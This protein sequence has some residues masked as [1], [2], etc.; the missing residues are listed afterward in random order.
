MA[1]QQPRGLFKQR[2][3]RLLTPNLQP[4]L[5]LPRP[6]PV[7][8]RAKRPLAVRH[9]FPRTRRMVFSPGWGFAGSPG[10]RPWLRP[11]DRDGP[12]GTRALYRGEIG[13]DKTTGSR[14]GRPRT[15]RGPPRPRARPLASPETGPDPA[16]DQARALGSVGSRSWWLF[17]SWG[18][19]LRASDSHRVSPAYEAGGLLLFPARKGEPTSGR[20]LH[21]EGREQS[22][23]RAAH[24]EER[25]ARRWSR[26]LS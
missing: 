2:P 4:L 26:G 25:G 22:E 21:P 10:P 16:P 9:S 5:R 14:C 15:P 12:W 1:T 20:L 11:A 7:R 3:V 24:K 17:G 18:S 8:Q 6:L 23:H 13:F 19:L